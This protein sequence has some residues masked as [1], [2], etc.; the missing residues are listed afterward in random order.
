[1][2]YALF[3]M[4]LLCVSAQAWAQQVILKPG[5][6]DSTRT[7]VFL[8]DLD[9]PP[10]YMVTSKVIDGEPIIYVN[11]IQIEPNPGRGR[12][13]HPLAPFD[14]CRFSFRSLQCDM[15]AAGYAR[16]EIVQAIADSVRTCPGV[17]AVIQDGFQL[18]VHYPDEVIEYWVTDSNCDP[19]KNASWRVAHLQR[20]LDSGYAYVSTPTGS[21]MVHPSKYARLLSEIVHARDSE[22]EDISWQVLTLDM[23]RSFRRSAVGK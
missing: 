18:K 15:K 22:S 7:L 16:D 19:D 11:G 20:S 13:H 1:M 12:R 3:L 2:F 6:V 10:P 23:V 14:Q 17:V 5:E 4:S 9:V 8:P 21:I